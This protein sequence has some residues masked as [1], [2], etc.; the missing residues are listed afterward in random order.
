MATRRGSPPTRPLAGPRVAEEAGGFL[1]RWAQRK[2]A[3]R[4]GNPLNEP[5]PAAPGAGPQVTAAQL[6]SVGAERP[7]AVAVSGDDVDASA[8]EP[9]TLKSL[10]LDDVK[11]LTQDSDFKPFMGRQVTPE[12]RNAA[13]RKLF[14]DPHFNVMDGLD[15]Y[16]DDYSKFE[17]IPESMLRQMASA[18]FLKLFEDDQDTASAPG[19][20]AP[21][22]VPRESANTPG[23]QT[24]AQSAPEPISQPA[25]LNNLADSP[26][27]HADTHLRL[28]PDHATEAPDAGRGT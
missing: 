21:L 17:P 27:D 9:P 26:Q 24:V 7:L 20:G 10:T 25:P 22:A 23:G 2:A 19:N 14:V 18:S 6:V 5:L 16:I 28:Q 13:M 1:G 8:A 3:A 12:V 4:Q 15:I 11:L